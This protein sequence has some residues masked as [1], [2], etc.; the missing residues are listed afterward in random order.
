MVFTFCAVICCSNYADG[1]KTTFFSFPKKEH[2]RKIWI[3]LVNRKDCELASSSYIRK[4]H[5][6]DKY[7]QK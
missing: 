2:L 7:Y 4:K 5:F 6:E 1:E 3:K